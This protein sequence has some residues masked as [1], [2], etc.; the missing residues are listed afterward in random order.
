MAAVCSDNR[1]TA[2]PLNARLLVRL[3][4]ACA[5]FLQ[6]A[7]LGFLCIIGLSWLMDGGKAGPPAGGVP[8]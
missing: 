5:T 8:Y 2:V 7:L 4:F 3:S 6:S 1:I